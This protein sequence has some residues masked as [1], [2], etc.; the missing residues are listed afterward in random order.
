[1][2]AADRVS[3]ERP[4]CAQISSISVESRVDFEAMKPG[5]RIASATAG[6]RS[7]FPVDRA[8]DAYRH[9]ESRA[10]FGKAVISHG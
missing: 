10:H 5:H 1:M 9:F 2:V 3:K 6:N 4:R 7:R 8:I